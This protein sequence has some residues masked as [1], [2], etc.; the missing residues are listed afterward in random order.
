[1]CF[2]DKNVLVEPQFYNY[3]PPWRIMVAIELLYPLIR[4]RKNN[5]FTYGTAYMQVYTPM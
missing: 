1:M 2:F 5:N 3:I 4:P